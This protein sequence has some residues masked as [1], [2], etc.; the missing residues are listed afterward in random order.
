MFTEIQVCRH[1]IRAEVK[2]ELA[3]DLLSEA[4]DGERQARAE[5][6]HRCKVL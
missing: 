4:I 1:I 2:L 6:R 5:R 3:E